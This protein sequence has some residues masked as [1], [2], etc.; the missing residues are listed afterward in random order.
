MP[1]VLFA[2]EWCRCIKASCFLSLAWA[3]KDKTAL[4][5][6]NRALGAPLRV[7]M[8]GCVL[9]RLLKGRGPA[10]AIPEV[11]ILGISLR[12][13]SQPTLSIFLPGHIPSGLWE[14]HQGS[15]PS[16]TK[17]QCF[18]S[19]ALVFSSRCQDKSESRHVMSSPLHG[20]PSRYLRGHLKD[21]WTGEAE[22]DDTLVQE[23][24]CQLSQYAR[25]HLWRLQRPCHML[26]S[27][28]QALCLFLAHP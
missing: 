14:S 5:I 1:I 10:L 26:Q 24:G 20:V 7:D 17:P 2:Q 16:Q 12:G 9:S 28:P 21:P 22:E 25:G 18:D 8:D 4:M 15:Q 11:G 27:L 23:N 13:A 19:K 3:C 6:Y